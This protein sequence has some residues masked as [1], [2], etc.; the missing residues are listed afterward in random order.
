MKHFL[1]ASVLG[2]SISISGLYAQQNFQVVKS[3]MTGEKQSD[4]FLNNAYKNLQKHTKKAIDILNLPND[5]RPLKIELILKNE[6]EISINVN[7]NKMFIGKDWLKH[8]YK[9]EGRVIYELAHLLLG[10][11]DAPKQPFWMHAGL[12]DYVR[13]ELGFRDR[14][15][16]PKSGGSYE[17][18]WTR[19]SDFFTYL[20]KKNDKAFNQFVKSFVSGTYSE[21]P[22]TNAFSKT[23]DQLWNQYQKDVFEKDRDTS[24]PYKVGYDISECPD[25]EPVAK[26]AAALCEKYYPI[27]SGMMYHPEGYRPINNMKLYFING[28]GY[29]GVCYGPSA[30]GLSAD[31]FRERPDDLGAVVHELTHTAQE[32]K[33]YVPWVT[34]GMTDYMRYKLGFR[35]RSRSKTRGSYKDGYGRAANFIFWIE[36]H[37]DKDIY[38]KLDKAHVLGN[39]TDGKFKEW[40]GKSVKE[41]WSMYQESFYQKEVKVVLKE[42]PQDEELQLYAKNAAKLIKKHFVYT[43]VRLGTP[44]DKLPKE[45]VITF[46]DGTGICAI[47][48][49][50]MVF[51]P[52]WVKE[53]L[54]DTGVVIYELAYILKALPEEKSNWLTYTIPEL[55]RTEIMPSEDAFPFLGGNYLTAGQTGV[56]FVQWLDKKHPGIIA[57]MLHYIR[58]DHTA[59]EVI[60]NK[61]GRN[62]NGAWKKYLK[63][64]GYKRNKQTIHVDYSKAPDLKE[65]AKLIQSKAGKYYSALIEELDSDHFT[66]ISDVYII[67]DTSTPLAAADGNKIYLN[68]NWFRTR[69]DDIGCIVHELTHIVQM[70]PNY[71]PFWFIEGTADYMRYK[72]GFRPEGAKPRKGGHYNRGYGDAANFID[73][74]VKTH[75]EDFVN[76]VNAVSREGIYRHEYIKEITGSNLD[77]LWSEYQKSFDK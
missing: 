38:F 67:F 8:N 16:F 62:T 30:I 71:H 32:Y 48:G 5:K 36:E 12:C 51:D 58:A 66:P 56:K 21:K 54:S 45:F 23:L 40:T 4:K 63:E 60:K 42:I 20:Q 3:A 27:I 39:Y 73:W 65:F 18:G 33:Q 34:E 44:L 74:I 14:F 57:E 47:E 52:K 25:I 35:P 19:A 50:A 1:S 24:I 43:A 17:E 70:I 22:I 64:N 6:R 49:N 55:I 28:L 10:L 59:D 72:Y 15:S 26:K 29:P 31:W 2:L 37:I 53:N 11:S 41:L 75:D 69:Q 61:T 76:K 13:S 46:R 7:G 77:T 9:D 68:P